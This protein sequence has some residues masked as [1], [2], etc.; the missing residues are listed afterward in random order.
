MT[1]FHFWSTSTFSA[2]VVVRVRSRPKGSSGLTPNPVSSQVCRK[3]DFPGRASLP[4]PRSFAHILSLLFQAGRSLELCTLAL[5]SESLQS[6]WIQG[7]K[8]AEHYCHHCGCVFFPSGKASHTARGCPS[9][10]HIGIAGHQNPSLSQGAFSS[11]LPEAVSSIPH[12]D[13]CASPVFNLL[14]HHQSVA[15]WN[16]ELSVA[17]SKLTPTASSLPLLADTVDLYLFPS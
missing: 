17:N 3:E 14:G 4:H 13:C 2:Q 12:L 11:Y 1:W 16:N 15:P 7:L 9:A 5:S 6:L 8:G 10:C